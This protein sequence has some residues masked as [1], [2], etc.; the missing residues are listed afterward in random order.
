MVPTMSL[1]RGLRVIDVSD[2]ICDAL[3]EFEALEPN[4]YALAHW[5]SHAYRNTLVV[6]AREEWPFTLRV[7][8][9][10]EVVIA[11]ARRALAEARTAAG[12]L[13][14]A[15]IEKLPARVHVVRIRD[16]AGATGYGPIDIRGATLTARVLSLFVADYLMRP[17]AYVDG[18][19][20]A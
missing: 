7:T 16:E 1:Q 19:R 4:K 13:D 9:S 5:L 11:E 12:R 8:S 14:G 10:V 2:R 20:A 18:E 17:D 3:A 15:F 6:G